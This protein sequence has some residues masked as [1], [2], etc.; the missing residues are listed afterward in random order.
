[1]SEHL[2]FNSTRDFSTGFFLPP[3]QTPEGVETAVKN[4]QALQTALSAPLA[5]ETGVNYMRPRPGEITDGEFVAAVATKANCGILL[6]LHN[7]YANELNGRQSVDDFLAGLPLDRVWEVHMAGGF[8]MDG[9]WLD[10]H[11][12]EI[13]DP[14][15]DRS[16]EIVAALTNLKAIIFEIFPSFV[17]VAGPKIIREQ[18][19]RLHLL[20]QLRGKANHERSSSKVPETISIGKPISQEEWE[21]VLG[22]LVIGR[23]S[24][25]VFANEMAVDPGVS[26][27]HRLIG[28]FRASMLVSVMRLTCRL[29]MLSLGDDPFRMILEDFWSK[30]PPRLYAS[31]EAESFAQYLADQKLALPQL[32]NILSFDRAVLATLVD[33]KNRVISFKSDPLPLLRALSEGHLT[34]FPSKAGDFEIE[35]TADD[36]SAMEADILTQGFRYH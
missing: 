5:I 35:I 8:E 11:S 1:V 3:C 24:P 32:N 25:G 33:G 17:A 28:E 4:I 36:A 7:I 18:I 10:A 6:D 23:Q 9:F 15:F 12:G 2:S 14:L 21:R 27:V 22:A 19:E 29:L 16:K 31:S 13:P 34:D 26:L 30:N 20:W